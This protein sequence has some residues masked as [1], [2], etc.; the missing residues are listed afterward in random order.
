MRL[1]SGLESI[2]YSLAVM[3]RRQRAMPFVAKPHLPNST[4]KHHDLYNVEMLGS[5][6]EQ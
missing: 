5:N 6:Q 2:P 1:G 3:E 4:P